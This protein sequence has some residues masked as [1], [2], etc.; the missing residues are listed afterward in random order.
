[1]YVVIVYLPGPVFCFFKIAVTVSLEMSSV[2]PVARVPVPFAA[3][4]K[5]WSWT[6]GL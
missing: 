3:I 2:R 4:F 5:T 1:M 6:L